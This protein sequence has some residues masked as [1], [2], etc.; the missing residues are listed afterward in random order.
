MELSGQAAI[1][2]IMLATGMALGIV[3]DC[4]RVMRALL[5]L[6]KVATAIADIL[7]WLLATGLV[8]LVLMLSN[9]GELRFYVFIGLITGVFCYYRLF[10]SAVIRLLIQATRMLAAAGRYGK[11]VLVFLLIKPLRLVA[12][13]V[14]FPF[15]FVGRK[16]RNIKNSL[17]KNWNNHKPPDG[18][19][20]PPQ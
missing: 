9:W 6:K 3:F 5:R 11:L 8:F 10:S 12:R 4:Y 13:V 7:Y 18:K 17:K 1:F 14:Y 19:E 20:I 2:G 16:V 15:G